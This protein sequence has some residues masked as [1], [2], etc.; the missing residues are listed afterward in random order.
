M[1]SKQK[2]E[3]RSSGCNEIDWAK[4]DWTKKWR[5][6]KSSARTQITCEERVF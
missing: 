4:V 5:L 3:D 1:P 6:R 2:P